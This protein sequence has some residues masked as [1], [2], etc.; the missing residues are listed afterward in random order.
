M[1]KDRHRWKEWLGKDIRGVL[2]DAEERLEQAWQLD[3][4]Y[5]NSYPLNTKHAFQEVKERIL[6]CQP[7]GRSQVSSKA[8][9]LGLLRT[10]PP[11]H[12]SDLVADG[13]IRA[14]Y[15]EQNTGSYIDA[16]RRARSGEK[17]AT[18]A[19]RKILNAVEAA[20]YVE[21]FGDD[22]AP[23][24]RVHFLHRNLLEIADSLDPNWRHEAIVDFLDYLCPCHKKHGLDAIRKLRQR[25]G[26][27]S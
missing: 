16:L 18:R 2:E 4:T 25:R 27:F 19:F 12:F 26:G 14:V 15:E 8:L 17:T 1:S 9:K 23:K 11:K 3:L 6:E 10:P 22:A 21:H 20:Y 5:P 7:Q 13:T 24:P